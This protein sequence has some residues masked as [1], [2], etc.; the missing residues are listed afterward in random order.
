MVRL[1]F[2]LAKV[3]GVLIIDSPLGIRSKLEGVS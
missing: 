2:I 3:G 1:L